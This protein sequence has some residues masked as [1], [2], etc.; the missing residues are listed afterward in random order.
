VLAGPRKLSLRAGNIQHG[1]RA[2]CMRVVKGLPLL[3]EVQL[4]SG[5]W[6]E[7]EVAVLLPPP[8]ALQRVELGTPASAAAACAA[9]DAVNSLRRH[10]VEVVV[11]AA[12]TKHVHFL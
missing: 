5:R 11:R 10:G 8:D 12:V 7:G 6:T 1:Q 2:Q 3:E 9:L 4:Q